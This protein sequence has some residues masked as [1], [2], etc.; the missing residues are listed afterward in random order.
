LKKASRPVNVSELSGQ[1]AAIDVYC[2]LH[3]GAFGC[4]EKLVQNQKTDGYVVY[5][6]RYV[7]LLLHHNIKPILVFDGRNLPSK[8]STEAK[9][10]ENRAKYRKMARDFLQ[11]GKHREA[12]ECFQRCVDITPEMAREVIKACNERRID[13]VVSPYEADAQLAYLATTGGIADFVI[14]EDSDLT[15]FG[16]QKIVF[17]LDANGNGVLYEKTNLHLCLGQRA[18]NFTFE[19][20]R[21]MGI[22]S[23]CDYLPSLHGIGL[24]K[25]CKFWGKVTNPNVQQVLPKIPAY[26]NM[27]QLQVTEEYVRGFQ[28]ANETFLYQIVFDPKSKKFRPLCDYPENCDPAQMSFAGELIDPELQLDYALGNLDIRTFK[29]V[30]HFE[31]SDGGGESGVE[32]TKYGRPVLHQRSIWD[33]NYDPS[34]GFVIQLEETEAQKTARKSKEAAAAI[35]SCFSAKA[36]PLQLASAEKPVSNIKEKAAAAASVDEDDAVEEIYS[37]A[38]S[39]PVLSLQKKKAAA[40]AALDLNGA[41]DDEEDAVEAIYSQVAKKKPAK[42]IY[43][44]KYFGLPS[45]LAKRKSDFGF[46][47]IGD[48]DDGGSPSAKKQRRSCPT[49]IQHHSTPKPKKVMK[50]KT[51]FP[52]KAAGVVKSN[53]DWMESLDDDNA[54]PST[55]DSIEG[56][57]DAALSPPTKA[58][59]AENNQDEADDAMTPITSAKSKAWLEALDDD[60]GL[61]KKTPKAETKVINSAAATTTTT[62]AAAA[63]QKTEIK[64]SGNDWFDALDEDGGGLDKDRKSTIAFEVSPKAAYNGGGVGA[65]AVAANKPFKPPS[66]VAETDESVRKRNPFAKK[67][68]SPLKSPPSTKKK[69]N[70]S[71]LSNTNSPLKISCSQVSTKSLTGGDDDVIECNDDYDVTAT[72][73]CYPSLPAAATPKSPPKAVIKSPPPSRKSL[74]LFPT[75]S[76]SSEKKRLSDVSKTSSSYFPPKGNMNKARVSGLLKKK[77]PPPPNKGQ[78]SILQMFG[79]AAAKH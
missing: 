25:S 60:G 78:P 1:V 71:L 48:D 59:K 37:Q 3:K 69:E 66:Q 62:A 41:A 49:E 16:C 74:E 35:N 54:P 7:D 47:S 79:K 64:S 30:C 52:V 50:K 24:G 67:L 32:K 34:Q 10:R 40:A 21:Y 42:E 2:W 38:V 63:S 53:S 18:D 75:S 55:D 12:R 22:M 77:P 28:Q 51:T 17:K 68:L 4:A 11:E 15:L 58:A 5:V 44:S 29:K 6:M 76:S 65:A 8:A 36:K 56:Q 31:P 61:G 73:S 57:Q 14:S 43:V 45:P 70:S 20:F 27:P 13:C 39:K 23:G 9:R 72:T 19:K 46:G 26:L 33:S